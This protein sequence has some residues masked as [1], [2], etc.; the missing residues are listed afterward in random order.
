V[1][2]SA[3]VGLWTLHLQDISPTSWTLRVL[4]ILPVVTIGIA[5]G[6]SFACHIY[7]DHTI[8]AVHV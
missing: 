5:V 1:L 8:L 3:V 6:C 7:N 4:H 2:K